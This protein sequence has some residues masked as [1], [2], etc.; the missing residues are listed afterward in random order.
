MIF[1][2]P[3]DNDRDYN[4]DYFDNDTYRDLSSRKLNENF[5]IYLEYLGND[6]ENDITISK[7]NINTYL[8]GILS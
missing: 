3:D 2:I 6:L 8:S 5:N 7:E 4:N 1:S